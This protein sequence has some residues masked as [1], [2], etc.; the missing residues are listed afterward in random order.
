MGNG[1]D[2]KVRDPLQDLL[3]LQGHHQKLL[4]QGCLLK[5]RRWQIDKG[6]EAEGRAQ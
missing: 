4:Q 3:S 2:F 1:M 5:G 6:V